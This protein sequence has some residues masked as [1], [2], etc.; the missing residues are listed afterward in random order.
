M[1]HAA[2]SLQSV[3]VLLASGVLAV[4]VC[5]RLNLPPMIGYLLTGLALGPHM[6]GLVSDREEMRSLAEFGVVF[7]MFSIGLEF[8]LPRLVAM[9]RVVFGLGLVQVAMTMA[10]AVGIV[11][12][13]GPKVMRAW[14]GVVARLRSNEI[15]VL[16]VLFITLLMAWLTALAGLSLVLG[17]FLAGMLISET[18]YRFRVEQDINPFRDVLLGLF[19]VTVGMMLDLRL[20]AAQLPLVLLFLALLVGAKFLLVAALA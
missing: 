9:R 10:L 19:F 3:L 2:V 17:A 1:D 15:F 13:A 5:R 16:N 20:V 8:S 7:L 14:L 18:E 12:V 4:V 11:I 6:L